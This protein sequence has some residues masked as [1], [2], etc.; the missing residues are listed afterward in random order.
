MFKISAQRAATKRL[1]CVKALALSVLVGAMK[2]F[3]ACVFV[4]SSFHLTAQDVHP[5][6]TVTFTLSA[7]NAREVSVSGDF[8]KAAPMTKND[9]G[10]WTVTI[11]PL[12]PDIHSYGFIVDGKQ[13]TDPL[14][15]RFKPQRVG[16]SNVFEIRGDKPAVWDRQNVPHGVVHLHEY[17]SKSVG[18]TRRMRVYTPPGY[19]GANN[20]RF[21]VLYLFHG[22]G[23]NEATWT[24]FGRAHDILDNLM[25]T[26]KAKSTLR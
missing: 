1:R 20:Q 2:I 8:G 24:D 26:G 6:G 7:P 21:P 19:D 9:A 25:A 16:T 23:D 15:N 14:S 5:D 10:V 11:G 18:A 12:D 22:S 13:I 17:D 3:F 4:A